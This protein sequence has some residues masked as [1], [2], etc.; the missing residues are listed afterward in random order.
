MPQL[1]LGPLMVDIEGLSLTQE[2]RELLRHPLVGGV[3]LFTRN[4]ADPQQV[5]ELV[6]QI[7]A[8]RSP[9]LMVAVDQEGGRVQR[10]REGFTRLPA[11]GL[12][13]EVYA[14]N[15]E[16]GLALARAHGWLMA[17]EQRAVGVDISFAPILDLHPGVSEIIGD[18]AFGGDVA[19]VT[20]LNRAYIS[21]M[22]AAGMAAT[23]K[24][25]PGHGSVAEDSHIAMPI[26]RRDIEAIKA[27][28]LQPFIQLKDAYDAVML[29]HVIYPAVDDLPAGFSPR[30]VRDWLRRDM[31]FDG[32]AFSDDLSMEG[33]V[34][35]GS[36]ADRAQA[37]WDAGCDMALVCNNRAGAIEVI[38]AHG[39]YVNKAASQRLERMLTR[40]DGAGVRNQGLND[41]SQDTAYHDA[42]GK[43]SSLLA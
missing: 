31:G 3:I 5:T 10:F 11:L 30:W 33:A 36:F 20:D 24:H 1:S 22:H 14:S 27:Y 29:A 35:I 21:G 37:A 39:N 38:D 34:A 43:L 2:D 23:A 18:R 15:P 41:L 4:Y 28:D 26:D 12:I 7:H 42:Q 40:H 17:S 9:R 13:G 6:K 32:V 19:T 8:L 16:E 25:F